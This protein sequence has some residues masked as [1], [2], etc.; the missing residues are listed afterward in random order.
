MRT[1]PLSLALCFLFSH[2]LNAQDYTPPTRMFTGGQLDAQ[3]QAGVMPTYVADKTTVDVPPLSIGISYLLSPLFGIDFIIGHST[4]TSPRQYFA[5]QSYARWTNSLLFAGVRPAVH[6]TKR[7]NIDIYGGMVL[8]VHYVKMVGKPGGD[9]SSARL[10][11]YESHLGI[12][13][14]FRPVFS[15]FLGARY[16][17]TPKMA[18]NAEI[19]FQV[20]ILSVGVG[21]RLR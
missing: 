20:S 9:L 1:I 8:G 12:H 14:S 16:A 19:G 6:F 3:F 7:D 15:G 13:D 17:L 21:Y 5:D 18:L 10:T 2:S 11:E 4:S